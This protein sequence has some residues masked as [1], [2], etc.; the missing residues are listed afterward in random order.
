[1]ATLEN[2]NDFCRLCK[3]NC[4]VR[5]TIKNT[6]QIWDTG[7]SSE[8]CERL[9]KLG[10]TLQQYDSKSC[11]ICIT[12]FRG[13]QRIEDSFATFN[14]WKLGEAESE[15]AANVTE[16]RDRQTTPSKTP[17]KVKKPRHLPPT[18]DRPPRRTQTVTEV[19]LR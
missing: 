11:R 6:K 3:Q 17:R 13:L 4:R 16:K 8:I 14:K 18:P 12:C 10:L 9:E 5:G 7:G 15:E 2:I 1:M 19:T